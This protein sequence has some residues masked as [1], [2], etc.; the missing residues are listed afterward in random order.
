MASWC[1]V[2]GLGLVQRAAASLITTI[3][4]VMVKAG[5]MG[6]A[7]WLQGTWREGMLG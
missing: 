5:V 1:T 4:K 3:A 2:R 7:F 6:V